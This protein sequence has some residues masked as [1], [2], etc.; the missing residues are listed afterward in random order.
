MYGITGKDLMS[1]FEQGKHMGAN[2]PYGGAWIQCVLYEKGERKGWKSHTIITLIVA[3]SFIKYHRYFTQSTGENGGFAHGL[4]LKG[5]YLSV[6]EIQR[7]GFKP[8]ATVWLQTG[9]DALRFDEP[10]EG[11][12]Y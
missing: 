6:D 7:L 9:T 2:A 10:K 3:G 4:S 1:D 5:M 8:R 12:D 11:L